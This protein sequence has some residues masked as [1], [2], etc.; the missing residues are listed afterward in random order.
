MT[1]NPAV[2]RR[3]HQLDV[4]R[5]ART[6]ATGWALVI[7]GALGLIATFMLTM[8]YLHYIN[9][10]DDKLLCDISVFVTCQPAM[11][12]QAGMIL[13]FPNFILGLVCFTIAVVSGVVI[14]SG[15]KLPNWYFW[16]LQIGLI[17]AAVLITY[18]QWYSGF[19]L[20]ALC[21]WCMA[22]W[23]V[24]IPLVNF[25]TIGNLA[26][27]RLG[28][29]GRKLGVA[30]AHWWWVIDVIWYVVV[31]GIVLA[32]MWEVLFLVA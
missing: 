8:E 17:G 27:G 18:L 29:R 24:T 2:D 16:G 30:L 12:S 20:K 10:P 5:V 3:E 32:G 14:L 6:G 23:T 19:V 28:Q 9:N 7:L 13:G 4:P 25:V 21:M 1:D 26:N 11:T 22:I 31:V 15:A